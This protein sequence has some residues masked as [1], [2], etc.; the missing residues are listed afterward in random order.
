MARWSPVLFASRAIALARMPSC[1]T[2]TVDRT[3]LRKRAR[4]LDLRRRDRVARESGSVIR[5]RA[6]PLTGSRG[7]DPS[8]PEN[9]GHPL[10]QARLTRDAV[11]S[12]E[13]D[14]D[15]SPKLG[16]DLLAERHVADARSAATTGDPARRDT[17]GGPRKKPPL[18]LP[19]GPAPRA[20]QAQ[21]EAARNRRSRARP[22]PQPLQ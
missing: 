13:T 3:H 14:S 4:V 21:P 1:S 12:P 5:D 11:A 19:C 6:D 8:A 15:D 10:R 9:T 22:R 20:P 16:D 18:K 2:R 7:H 17:T